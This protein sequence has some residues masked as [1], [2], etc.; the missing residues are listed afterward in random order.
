MQRV[1]GLERPVE[2]GVGQPAAEPVVLNSRPRVDDPRGDDHV[3]E[4]LFQGGED[5]RLVIV[6]DDPGGGIA[7]SGQL[8]F[9]LQ[10]RNRSS[11]G[12]LWPSQ[13]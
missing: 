6:C 3:V 10:L 5:R 4:D 11:S 2:V 13:R 8:M 12:T 7:E 1:D 9:R